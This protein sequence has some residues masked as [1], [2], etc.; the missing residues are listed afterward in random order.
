[1]R[2]TQDS[3]EGGFH[4]GAGAACRELEGAAIIFHCTVQQVQVTAI[5]RDVAGDNTVGI[6]D[7]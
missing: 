7:L 5:P 1:M 2:E 4:L 6:G 3:S